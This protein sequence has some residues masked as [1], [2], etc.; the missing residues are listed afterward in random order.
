M[1]RKGFTLIEL[2]VVI[3]IIAILIG[4]LLPAVQK[5]RQ[6]AARMTCQNNLKQIGLA[7][8]SYESAYGRFPPG[9]NLPG[10]SNWPTAP[11]PGQYFG[12]HVAM[13]PY[14]EQD[15]LQRNLVTDH[16]NP[17]LFNCAGA[18]SVGAQVVK[19]LVC[20]AD[21][22][23]PSPPVAHYTNLTFGLTSYGGC[24]G[25]S[26]TDPDGRNMRQDGIF[27]FNSSV[28][29]LDITDGT[30][31]TLMFGERSRLNLGATDTSQALGGWA[32]VNAF[33]MEDNTMNASVPIEGF[34]S[35]DINAFG[36]QHP[37]NGAN[38]TFA[39][40]SVKFI[41]A[42]VDLFNVLQPLATRAKGEVVDASQY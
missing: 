42:S 40:G 32:W 16:L 5:V 18:T 25:A 20:P 23:M 27:Y 8:Y 17:H 19:I 28:Y 34:K 24:S 41:S 13:F 33:A 37:G 21:S 11:F 1:R 6:A 39:D 31:Q 36:S 26:A 12:L 9:V 15:N 38:F 10:A 22:A 14:Y 30:S 2:L 35:H 7:A 4:L 3:A 29:V